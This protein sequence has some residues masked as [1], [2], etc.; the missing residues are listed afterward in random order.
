M[1]AGA[2]R[3]VTDELADEPELSAARALLRTFLEDLPAV[4]GLVAI[5]LI[6]GA[7]FIGPLFYRTNQ[8]TVNLVIANQAPSAAHMLGTDGNGYDILGRLMAGGQISIEVGFAVGLVSTAVGVIYGTIAG[9][10]GRAVDAVM[11]RFIDIGLSIPTVFLFIFVSRLVTPSVWLLI[12]L[13]SGMSWLVPARLVRGDILTLKVREYVQAARGLGARPWQVIVRHLVPNSVGII[14][15][16]ATFQIA[17]AILM[18]AV[19]QFLGFSIPPPTPSWGTM[20]STGINYLF[21]GYWWQV[22]PALVAIVLLVLAFNL[23]GDG[24]RDAFEVRL[25]RR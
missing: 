19:L 9:Y 15:V 1:P 16:N 4:A 18:L 25:Q 17:N 12:A 5:A 7:C 8:V 22:Y 11:M 20:L 2:S 13:L 21:D 3:R 14:V 10:F 24:L 6:V 23:V